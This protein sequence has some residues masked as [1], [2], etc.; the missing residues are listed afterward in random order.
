MEVRLGIFGIGG[1]NN[2]FMMGADYYFDGRW[3]NES[4][5]QHKTRVKSWD[6]KFK[7]KKI[8]IFK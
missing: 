2:D 4:K 5:Q 8:R 3:S 6:D 1:H 7:T